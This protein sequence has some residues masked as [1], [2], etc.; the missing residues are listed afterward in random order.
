[1]MCHTQGAEKVFE[2]KQ[3]ADCS[4]QRCHFIGSCS[5]A[6]S[7]YPSV[8]LVL[9]LVLLPLINQLAPRLPASYGFWILSS[10]TERTMTELEIAVNQ[11][12]GE[13]EVIQESGTTLK[14][15]FGPGLTGMRNL[16]NSCY[17]NSV[18]QVLFTVPD[19]QSKSVLHLFIFIYQSPSFIFS[20]LLL[21][22]AD[23]KENI[24]FKM[25]KTGE[26][27]WFKVSIILI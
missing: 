23:W 9:L 26:R 18:M 24:T 12:V 20:Q 11:R 3:A 14:P 15:L 13:W 4:T 16:G 6:C 19:F 27:N 10:Q 22:S 8:P 1:M 25:N 17:L 2:I 21:L 7:H 5:S